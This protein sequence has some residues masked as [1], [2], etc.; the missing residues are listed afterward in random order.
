L[1]DAGQVLWS[2]WYSYDSWFQVIS[3]AMEDVFKQFFFKCCS[4]FR[5]SLVGIGHIK[6]LFIQGSGQA[7]HKFHHPLGGFLPLL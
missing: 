6:I 5:G 2:L 1:Q 7:F 3:E 4:V